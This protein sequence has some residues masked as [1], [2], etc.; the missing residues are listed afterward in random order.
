MTGRERPVLLQPVLALEALHPSC[1]IQQPLLTG[2]KGM[3]LGANFDVQRAQRGARF[4]GVA[5]GAGHHATAILGMNSSFHTY[6]LSVNRNLTRYQRHP[7]QTIARA[8]ARRLA[9][10]PMI[11]VVA[12]LCCAAGAAPPAPLA[13]NPQGF[14]PPQRNLLSPLLSLTP[15]GQAGLALRTF[16]NLHRLDRQLILHPAFSPALQ[17]VISRLPAPELIPIEMPG[18]ATST[19]IPWQGDLSGKRYLAVKGRPDGE[20]YTYDLAENGDPPREPGHF[21]AVLSVSPQASAPGGKAETVGTVF[22]AF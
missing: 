19:A 18:L 7:C 8:L 1:R 10:C 3:A 12:A 9:F 2:V 16:E 14:A 20:N 11:L 5:A 22:Q 6:N 21:A 17:S 13:P 4:E 15:P